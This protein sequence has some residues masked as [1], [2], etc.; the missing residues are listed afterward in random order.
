MRAAGLDSNQFKRFDDS[1]S[2]PVELSRILFEFDRV[3]IVGGVTFHYFAGFS[4][5]RKLICPGLA[6]ERTI[7]ATHSLAF[8]CETKSR[9][10]GVGPG[11]LEGN[12]V[13][14]AFMRI[15]EKVDPVFSVNAIVNSDGNAAE[16][17]CGNWKSAH[18]AA[19]DRYALRHAIEIRG[20]RDLVIAS[21]G[22]Y[23]FDLD[24]IQA[25]KALEA[26][27]HAC[28]EGGTIILLAECAEGLGRSDFLKWFDASNSEEIAVNL[29]RNYE[30]NGQTA[31]SLLRIT[32]RFDVRILSALSVTATQQMHLRSVQSIY[33]AVTKNRAEGYILPFGAKFLIKNLS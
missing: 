28:V 27:S 2:M 23:P 9:R 25:H 7:T 1:E 8:D 30:V 11:K 4:G 13:N 29:C 22:G 26:A 5:G 17:F 14:D 20:K 12:A 21:C 15:T 32:E 24:M 6:S 10:V 19:C 16:V 33:E 3:I 31:W 18:R